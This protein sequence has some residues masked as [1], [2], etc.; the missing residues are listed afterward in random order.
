MSNKTT[1]REHT[2]W[3]NDPEEIEAIMEGYNAECDAEDEKLDYEAAAELCD[4]YRHDEI[5][6][7]QSANGRE[8]LAIADLGRWNGRHTGYKTYSK[9]TEVLRRL[10]SYSA[11]VRFYVDENGEFCGH[12]SHHDGT[13]YIIYRE[14]RADCSDDDWDRLTDAIYNNDDYDALLEYCTTPV[15]PKIQKVYGWIN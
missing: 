3:S 11:Y 10:P 6:N 1:T 8:I 13:D 5:L 12:F 14:R 15:G 2:I 7:L 4:E 9:L